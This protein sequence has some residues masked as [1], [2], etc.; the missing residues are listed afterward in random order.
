[1]FKTTAL[2]N[3]AA[4]KSASLSVEN[5]RPSGLILNIMQKGH[6]NFVNYNQT[7]ATGYD[8]F[9]KNVN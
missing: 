2:E 3:Q 6:K 8:I 5:H 4:T 9:T 7:A 1:M